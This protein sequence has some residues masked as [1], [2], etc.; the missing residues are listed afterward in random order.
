MRVNGAES[1]AADAKFVEMQ[2][3]RKQNII[4]TCVPM[5]IAT[6]EFLF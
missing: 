3:R 2:Q 4:L 6:L 1:A 5:T